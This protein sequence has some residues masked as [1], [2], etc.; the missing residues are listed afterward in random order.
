MAEPEIKQRLAA[1]LAAD[2]A[3]YSR[4]MGDDERATIATINQCR[5]VF[6]EAIEANGGRVVDMAG[7]SVLAIFD[8]AIGA[9][10]AA[11]A[12]QERLAAL[13]ADLA[14][15][16]RMAWRIGLNTGDIHEQDD[17]TVYGDG[18]NVAA[19]LQALAEPGGICLSDKVH[20]EV[21]AKLGRG[22]ADLGTH[23]V[24]NI[25]EPV[26]AYRVL[27]E[28]ETAPKARTVLRSPRAL[29]A[30]V[31]AVV[32][33]AGIAIWQVTA[34]P[35]PTQITA[36]PEDPILALPT[37]PSI[38]VLPFDT[39]SEDPRIEYFA[40]GLAEDITTALTRFPDLF[41]ISRNSTFQYKGQAVDVREVGRD[42]G[43]EYV[44]EG[45]VR[46]S[47]DR[48]RVTAQLLY[49]EDGSHLWAETFDRDFTATDL[50][51]IQDEITGQVVSTIADAWGVL[52]QDRLERVR[53][54][55]T[56]DLD[57]Y[58]CVA[59]V[60][61]YIRTFATDEH[62]AVRTCLEKTV[63]KDP[64]Y[65]NAWAWLAR[66]V[67]DE[68]QIYQNPKPNSLDRALDAAR[69]AVELDP[70]NDQAQAALADAHFH[71]L[72]MDEFTAAAERT[73]ALN[74]NSSA[75]LAEIGYQYAFAGQW[76]RGIA[77]LRKAQKLNPRHPNWYFLITSYYYYGKEQYE[78]ALAE[79]QNINMPEFFNT[80]LILAMIY[81]Q[82]G[83]LDEAKAA[84]EKLEALWP[85]FT[86]EDERDFLSRNMP[87]VEVRGKVFDGLRK[88]GLPEAAAA[89]TRPVIAVL[90]FD[91]LSTEPEHQFFADGIAEDII[92]RLARFPD[93]GVIARNSS[94][95]YKGESV[96]VRAVAEELGATYVLE[97]SCGA[98]KMRFG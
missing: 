36:A 85:G 66:M 32:A 54:L 16:R 31:V 9:A 86:M 73:L 17:G 42:L 2:V 68:Y 71:R 91:S 22:F 45:G 84:L 60:Q 46:V 26:R 10:T 25:A 44:L 53:G 30:A 29:V 47:D 4:L 3:G 78:E 95:Q 75:A 24:K 98:R 58:A 92:T 33:L 70:Q 11:V 8:T 15:E 38:A 7:D 12:V 49:A 88:A 20:A 37:G 87:D 5:A 69:R 51:A 74:R 79:A 65:A 89:P 41:V 57:S 82:M 83:R 43:A 14:E 50:F 13:N 19:R 93:I 81:G 72:E 21:R 59:R 56:D 62:L 76:D 77:L 40:D 27:A 52:A 94:F 1:I 97:G 80:H 35:E 90:P 23:E 48:I 63:E 28:G 61:S 18:V 34:T 6:R 96:D 55:G 64:G 67:V 39:F